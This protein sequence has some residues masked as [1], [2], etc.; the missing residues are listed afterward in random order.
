MRKPL[1]ETLTLLALAI[2]AALLMGPTWPRDDGG[3]PAAQCSFLGSAGTPTLCSTTDALPTTT[4]GPTQSTTDPTGWGRTWFQATG[5]TNNTAYVVFAVEGQTIYAVERTGGNVIRTFVSDNAGRTFT[6]RDTSTFATTSGVNGAV[7][8]TGGQFLLATSDTTTNFA[9]FRSASGFQFQRA[10]GPA[11]GTCFGVS[12]P[13]FSIAAQGNTVIASG[14]VGRCRS[15][16]GGTTFPSCAATAPRSNT[17]H[18]LASPGVNTW[19]GYDVGGDS[20]HRST[21]DGVTWVNVLSGFTGGAGRGVVE[22]LSGTVCL[23]AGG[24][25]IRRSTNAGATW[26]SVFTEPFANNI[27]GLLSFGSGVAVA[28]SPN[29][30]RVYRT[31]DSGATWAFQVIGPDIDFGFTTGDYAGGQV[32]NGRGVFAGT[33]RASTNGVAYSPIVGAGETIVAG[34]S[35][36]RWD[37]DTAGAGLVRI[38]PATAGARSQIEVNRDGFPQCVTP[39][40]NTAAVITVTPAAGSTAFLHAYIAFYDVAPAAPQTLTVAFA[41]TTRW[42]D[43][44]GGANIPTRSAWTGPLASFVI[45]EAFTVTLPAGGAGVSGTLCTAHRTYVF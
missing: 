36:N 16:D 23:A 20:V 8:T 12:C 17:F 15:T 26:T 24:T 37:I 9:V 14:N 39:A 18:T 44:V 25:T 38:N 40:A 10:T 35:G 7:R 6:L 43:I 3:E 21:D 11:S 4:L 28:W 5:L 2:G 41:A 29:A 13:F 27:T 31:A 19:L 34:Q 33:G 42:R 1:R 22:C 32:L 30:D 45:S